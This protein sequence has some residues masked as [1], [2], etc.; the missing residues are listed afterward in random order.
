M[1][2]QRAECSEPTLY[3]HFDSKL[4]LFLALLRER[5]DEARRPWSQFVEIQKHDGNITF[6]SMIP[7]LM[8]NAEY[9]ELTQLTNLAVTLI[10]EPQVRDELVNIHE[11]TRA[12]TRDAVR[13]GQRQGRIRSDLD[14]DYVFHMW[15]A[16]VHAACARDA[17][18]TTNGF[19]AMI[20]HAQTF[21]RSLRP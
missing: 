5:T 13:E 19:D 3:K 16:I 7:V 1:I 20:P 9:Q 8:G 21:V 12:R 11:R 2:A 15:Q 17:I 4:D 6:E 14:P 10:D 18:E